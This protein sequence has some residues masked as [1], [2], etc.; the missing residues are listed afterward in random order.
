VN[1]R[2]VTPSSAARSPTI[3]A[4]AVRPIGKI[5]PPGAAAVEASP[6]CQAADS[7]DCPVRPPRISNKDL[8]EAAH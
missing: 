7:P 3:G 8:I 2:I 1:T 5:R 6:R 4:S